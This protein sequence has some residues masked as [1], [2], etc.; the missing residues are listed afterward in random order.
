MSL[1]VFPIVIVCLRV[2]GPEVWSTIIVIP[3]WRLA[4][5][6]N[7]SLDCKIIAHGFRK[8]PLDRTP[9]ETIFRRR[10]PPP[11]SVAHGHIIVYRIDVYAGPCVTRCPGAFGGWR[12]REVLCFGGRIGSNVVTPPE[13]R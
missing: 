11:S 4:G 5:F 8:M 1:A 13:K 10:R 7:L 9:L 3:H 12:N 6:S 2:F